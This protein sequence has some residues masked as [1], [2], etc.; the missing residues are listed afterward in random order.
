MWE[1]SIK[2]FLLIKNSSNIGYSLKIIHH[3]SQN[4]IGVFDHTKLNFKFLD[5]WGILKNFSNFSC[6]PSDI[7]G[8]FWIKSNIDFNV[9]KNFLESK[10]LV[11]DM[12]IEG[13][14]SCNKI[15]NLLLGESV[16]NISL[17]S[18]GFSGNGIS[19]SWLGWISSWGESSSLRFLGAVSFLG[20][21]SWSCGISSWSSGIGGLTGIGWG[22]GVGGFTGIGWGRGV[23]FSWSS[24]V[25]NFAC[26]CWGISL[27]LLQQLISLG[28]LLAKLVWVSK[29]CQFKLGISF[30]LSNCG[31]SDGLL[32]I[33]K[34]FSE[35]LSEGLNLSL[36]NSIVEDDLKL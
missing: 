24:A 15:I 35:T 34:L 3:F 7:G 22:S 18:V 13:L 21:I 28:K 16:H 32:S 12:L 33:Y 20:S 17:L 9:L 8:T 23:L 5:L 4:W 10:K 25:G 36:V 27:K 1:W 14:N 6:D 19:L 31:K 26:I 11:L 29:S 30:I 2:L